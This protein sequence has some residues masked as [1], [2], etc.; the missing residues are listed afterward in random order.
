MDL[1]AIQTILFSCQLVA[2][3]I[4][5]NWLVAPSTRYVI[6]LVASVGSGVHGVNGTL[7]GRLEVNLIYHLVRSTISIDRGSNKT[8]SLHN[9]RLH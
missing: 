3:N 5:P 1:A 9:H 7:Q 8:L 2:L 4:L 6:K